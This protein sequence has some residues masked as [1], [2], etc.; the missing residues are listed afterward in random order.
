[1]TLEAMQ[2]ALSRIQGE[3]ERMVLDKNPSHGKLPSYTQHC[4][5]NARERVVASRSALEEV[6]AEIWDE[7]QHN[8]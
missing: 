7:E 5:W 8:A 6:I 2:D 1:M 3:L 4:I